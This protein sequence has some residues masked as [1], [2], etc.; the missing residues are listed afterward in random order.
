MTPVVQ[1]LR[2][3]V[4]LPSVNPVFL[5]AGDV[6]AGEHRVADFLIATA[7]KAGL[8]VET[9]EVFLGRSNIFARLTPSGPVK[10]RIVLAPHMDTV[11]GDNL[12]KLLNPEIRNGRLY[13]RGA[14]DTKGCV[15]AMLTAV[16][17]T[18]RSAQRPQETEIIFIG[19]I[20]EEVQQSGSR[21]VAASGFEAD[22]AIVG[23]PTQ[24][25]VITAHK[26]DVWLWLET[27]GKAAHGARP[28]L[29]DNAIHRM[30]KVVDLLETKYAQ[31]LKKR[32]NPLLGHGTVNVG[33][34]Q[35]GF[36][37]NIVPAH[38]TISIDRRTLP[39]ETESSVR[40]ELAAFFKQHGVKVKLAKGK[41]VPCLALETN[42]KLPLVQAAVNAVESPDETHRRRLFLRCRRTRTR[43]H[44]QCRVRPR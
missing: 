12:D 29:G 8:S 3:L 23:E 40:R 24:L 30:A 26:G 16:M 21:A 2:D 41:G 5:P 37:S 22:L 17:D 13:G 14:C 39:G 31:S 9:R 25:K 42:H 4:A 10:R 18:A 32:K 35:G 7:A 33:T 36:Q 34:I 44:S 15:A 11:G 1:L 38:C 6:R 19:L 43:R 20:D 27:T 28:E